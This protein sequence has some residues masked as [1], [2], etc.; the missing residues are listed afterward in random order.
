LRGALAYVVE[1]GDARAAFQMAEAW[2]LLAWSSRADSKEAL[3][4]LEAA[5]ILG[6]GAEARVNA[7]I[8]AASLMGLRGD[9]P[10]AVALA[11]EGRA[12]AEAHDYPFGVAYALFYGGVIAKLR[13]DLDTAAESLRGAIDGWRQLGEAY[14]V[15]LAL[16]NLAD[17]VLA[18][19]DVAAAGELAREGLTGSR[20]VG[21]A[22]GTALG[23]GSLAAVACDQGDVS[24][25]LQHYAESFAL[26]SAA[27]DQRGVAGTLAGLAG[28]AAASGDYARAARLLGAAT[29]LGEAVEAARLVHH[30][31]YERALAATQAALDEAS[32]SQAWAAG[33]ALSPTGIASMVAEIEPGADPAG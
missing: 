13:G 20:E 31:R 24:L 33:R 23:F 28:V 8:A 1:R 30:E 5:L 21:D 22:Y 11:D 10:R 14:W 29:A 25:A 26:W 19:G 7:L 9:L 6:G 2:Q 4:W 12:V 16:N 32:F 3:R 27:G 17:V 15:A 18:Q